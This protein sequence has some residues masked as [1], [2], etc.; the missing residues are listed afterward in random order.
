MA[1]T[2]HR[3]DSIVNWFVQGRTPVAG[4]NQ[5]TTGTARFAPK[6]EQPFRACDRG[7][8]IGRAYD[9]EGRSSWKNFKFGSDPSEPSWRTHGLSTA[10][11]RFFHASK[12]RLKKDAR[13]TIIEEKMHEA[14][15]GKF[16]EKT[17]SQGTQD[18]TENDDLAL[19]ILGSLR[20]PMGQAVFDL[21]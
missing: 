13:E 2:R 7:I 3:I 19:E 20:S 21:C 15:L 6:A 11:A 9:L 10:W 18:T 14:N 5:I 4:R 8:S 17:A 1:W 16:I 12:N